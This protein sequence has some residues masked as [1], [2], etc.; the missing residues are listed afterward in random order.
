MRSAT[1][2]THALAAAV[3]GILLLA[4]AIAGSL[5]QW[6]ELPAP[7]IWLDV[8]LVYFLCALPLA[9]SVAALVTTRLRWSNHLLAIIGL[10]TIVLAAIPQL[11]IEA[12]S[13]SDVARVA[14]LID[15]SRLAEA[16]ALLTRVL[17]LDPGAR[18]KGYSLRQAV[19]ELDASIREIEGRIAA[20]LAPE[21]TDEDRLGRARDLAMLGQ[22]TAAIEVLKSSPTLLD[23]PEASNLRGTIH[24]TRGDWQPARQWYNR[25][26]NAWQSRAES[27]EQTAGLVQATTGVAFCERKLGRLPQ[28]EAA[29]QAVL[30]LSPTADSHFLLA[31]FYEDTQQA[32]KAQ[33]H[34]RQAISLNPQRYQSD[35]QKLIDK[36]ITLHFGCWGAATAERSPS[37]TLATSTDN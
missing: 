1:I 18:W 26:R 30:A 35:G 15:Q 27:P 11:Y 24:E 29:Y 32:L 28:A 37:S 6:N 10:E 4:C 12:R 25:A 31:Q 36:L 16:R 33:A 34:A 22:T 14:G 3:G 8:A 17:A 19:G 7:F 13:Q 9:A 21:A 20:P 23:W 2:Q 5:G